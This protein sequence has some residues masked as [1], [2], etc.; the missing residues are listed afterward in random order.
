MLSRF[1]RVQLFATPWTV[2]HQAPLS[3]GLFR[4]GYWSGL[5][6][7]P[8]AEFPDPGIEA[9]SLTRP[10]SAGRFFTTSWE[11][12]GESTLQRIPEIVRT[13]SPWKNDNHLAAER[14]GCLF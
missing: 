2:A 3:A 8:P 11:H 12:T 5:P 13:V 7:P 4:Q 9:S 10:A 1:S 14:L 6:R